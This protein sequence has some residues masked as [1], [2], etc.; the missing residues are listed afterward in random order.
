MLFSRELHS[1]DKMDV[2]YGF[3]G[4]SIALFALLL[5]ITS[6][7]SITESDDTVAVDNPIVEESQTHDVE[8]PAAHSVRQHETPEDDE[9]QE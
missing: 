7:V 9:A 2:F 1:K 5:F 4:F 8:V 6:P 3:G